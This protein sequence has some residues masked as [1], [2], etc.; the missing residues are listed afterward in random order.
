M[1]NAAETRLLALRNFFCHEQREQVRIGPFFLFGAHQQV[2]PHATRVGEMQTLEQ[3]IK[4][5][6]VQQD[7]RGRGRPH[8]N[9]SGIRVGAACGGCAR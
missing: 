4:V 1:R 8:V 6:G 2:A 5:D 3:R 7:R 9:R